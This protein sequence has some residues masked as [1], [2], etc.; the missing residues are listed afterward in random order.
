MTS[1]SSIINFFGCG[2]LILIGM[3][4]FKLATLSERLEA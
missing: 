3:L 4:S 2:A 1:A